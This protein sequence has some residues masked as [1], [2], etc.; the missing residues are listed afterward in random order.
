MISRS[1]SRATLHLHK[2]QRQCSPR[3]VR[4][5]GSLG[6]ERECHVHALM[7]NG[8]L[9]GTT[10]LYSDELSE[11]LEAGLLTP[12]VRHYNYER[13]MQLSVADVDLITVDGV[14]HTDF[15]LPVRA[16][17]GDGQVLHVLIVWT[18]KVQRQI[19][20]AKVVSDAL[21]ALSRVSEMRAS[22]DDL[23]YDHDDLGLAR[24]K[25]LG[26]ALRQVEPTT[27]AL[28]SYV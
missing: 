8:V 24:A 11:K 20:H 26:S 13:G 12:F 6:E 18:E 9:T 10:K 17:L 2:V 4:T 22:D 7:P 28:M 25:S 14:P 5:F 15:S 23:S 27:S 1:R 3:Q 16:L 21:G 19:E